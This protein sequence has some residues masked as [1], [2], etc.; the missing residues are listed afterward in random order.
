M[1]TETRDLCYTSP[2][3]S[4][5]ILGH[6]FRYFDCSY[7]SGGWADIGIDGVT[8]R[9]DDIPKTINFGFGSVTLND[10]VTCDLGFRGVNITVN[11]TDKHKECRNGLCVDID[12][13]GTNQCITDANCRHKECQSGSCTEMMISGTDTCTIDTECAPP[14]YKC[15]GAPNYACTVDP[16]GI[17]NTMVACL[18][19]CKAD[20]NND[21]LGKYWL[22]ILIIVLIVIIGIYYTTRK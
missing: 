12:G 3:S 17:H 15:S 20:G 16:T 13:T 22:Y 21:F 14:K 2:P 8:V 7:A 11:V 1:T 6:T 18:D 5:T 19:A 10:C 4:I 9:F